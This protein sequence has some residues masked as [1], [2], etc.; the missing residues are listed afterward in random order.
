[1]DIT[2][3]KI[4]NSSLIT[5]ADLARKMWPTNKSASD[6]L[7]HKIAGR[8]GQRLTDQDKALIVEVFKNEFSLL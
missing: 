6:K 2:W 3:D 7:N 1:M 5:K 4:L 8:A